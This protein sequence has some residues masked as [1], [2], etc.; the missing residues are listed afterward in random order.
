MIRHRAIRSARV[1]FH[2][3]TDG[4]WTTA[5]RDGTYRA[6]SLE[7]EGFVHLST[8]EQWPR[9]AARFFRGRRGL[10]LLVIDPA[11]LVHEVRYEAADGESFPHLYG[12][13]PVEAVV[14]VDALVPDP[15][16]LLR[17]A[18]RATMGR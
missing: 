11:R 8:H 9:T 1:L 4:S 14:A 10:V 6:P 16:G 13:L 17:R 5:A 18:P 3:T 7:T 15:Q 12:P 2:I